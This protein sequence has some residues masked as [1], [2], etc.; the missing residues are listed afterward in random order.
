MM[1]VGSSQGRRTDSWVGQG[2][3]IREKVKPLNFLL[4]KMKEL[5][6]G[7]KRQILKIEKGQILL[8]HKTG[9]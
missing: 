3:Q 8:K 2:G 5:K 1:I 6:K 7:R 9:V 4:L